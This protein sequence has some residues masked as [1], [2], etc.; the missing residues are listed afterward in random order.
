MHTEENCRLCKMTISP[1]TNP[2]WIADFECSIAFVNAKQ[3]FPGRSALIMRSH[4]EDL[5]A[6]SEDEFEQA[7][8]EVRM[9]ATA[10]QDVFQADRMNFANFGNVVPHLHWHI[11]PRYVNDICWGGPP[12]QPPVSETLSDEEYQ[13]IANRIRAAL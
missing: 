3:D 9:L 4:Y 1:Q 11:I 12:I 8:R 10:V 13:E 5:L 7:N 6:V 2:R